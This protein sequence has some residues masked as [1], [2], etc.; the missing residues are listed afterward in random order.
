MKK[1]IIAC[2]FSMGLVLIAAVN[3]MT[4]VDVDPYFNLKFENVEGLAFSELEGTEVLHTGLC[5]DG[6]EEY[7]SCVWEEDGIGSLCTIADERDCYE[8]LTPDDGST[9]EACAQYGHF[10]SSTFCFTTC[11]RCGYTIRHCDD[12]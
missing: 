5:D 3:L 11:Y 7:K 1:K 10:F 2:F 6:V 12:L 4:L 8:G 9:N